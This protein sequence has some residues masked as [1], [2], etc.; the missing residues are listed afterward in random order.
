MTDECV[1]CMIANGEIPATAVYEDETVFAFDDI[2]PQAPVH[3]LIV[4]RAH[5]SDISDDVP[6]DVLLALMRAV[7][8]VAAAKGVAASGYR[9]IANTGE[10]AGQTVHHLHVHVIGGRPL[11]EGMVRPMEGE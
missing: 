8:K 6:D 7:P 5:H 3:V 2:A 9:V 10:D 4:P 1:F 11:G